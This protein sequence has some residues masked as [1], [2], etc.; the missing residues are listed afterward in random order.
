M[1]DAHLALPLATGHTGAG[2]A[3]ALLALV[4]AGAVLLGAATALGIVLGRRVE[5]GGDV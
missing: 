4:L 2:D 1:V 3:P 5:G